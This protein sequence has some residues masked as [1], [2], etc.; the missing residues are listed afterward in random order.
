MR[1][2]SEL[3]TGVLVALSHNRDATA[4]EE[5]KRMRLLD[6][7]RGNRQSLSATQAKLQ[8]AREILRGKKRA[9]FETE[10]ALEA[11]R[12]VKAFS[13]YEL[14]EGRTRA[15]GAEGKRSRAHV[16]DRLVRLGQSISPAQ[17]NDYAWL[18]GAWGSKMLVEHADHWPAVFIG[19]AQHLVQVHEEGDRTAASNILRSETQRCYVGEVALVVP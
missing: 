13:V 19:W 11:K 2:I 7:L 4:A 9:L 6:E 18:K 12:A 16:L 8:E 5:R 10:L 15:G 14:G 1:Q 3:D 17:R